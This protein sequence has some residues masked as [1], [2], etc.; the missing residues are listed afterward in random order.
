[1]YEY[2]F[3][4]EDHLYSLETD[5]PRDLPED[6]IHNEIAFREAMEELDDE[7]KVEWCIVNIH[8]RLSFYQN[9]NLK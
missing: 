3:T 4:P 5:F 1:M 2:D 9:W 8:H 6:I 7:T